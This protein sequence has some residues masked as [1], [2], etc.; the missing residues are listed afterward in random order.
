MYMLYFVYNLAS[1]NQLICILSR[2]RHLGCAHIWI[3][4]PIFCI[5]ICSSDYACVMH[6]FGLD[7][8]RINYIVIGNCL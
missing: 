7:M 3:Y 8:D 5:S 1:L 6:I 4:S 2:F